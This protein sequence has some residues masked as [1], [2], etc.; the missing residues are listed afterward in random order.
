MWTREINIPTHDNLSIA[1]LEPK[2]FESS[3]KRHNVNF[4][5]KATQ[6]NRHRLSDRH[7]HF[8]HGT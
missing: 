8:F 6:C 7:G 5:A 2:I 3:N 1:I 4:V